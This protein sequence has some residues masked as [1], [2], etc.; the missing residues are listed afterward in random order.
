[1]VDVNNYRGI[2]ILPPIAKLFEK[3]IAQQIRMYFEKNKLLF[4]YTYPNPNPIPEKKWVQVYGNY[5]SSHP[6]TK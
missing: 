1:M 4:G 6:V 2:S 5:E 3:L